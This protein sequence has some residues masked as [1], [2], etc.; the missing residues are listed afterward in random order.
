[1]M[2]REE[3]SRVVHHTKFA[4]LDLIPNGTRAFD[5]PELLGR[6]TTAQLLAELRE[7]YDVIICDSPPLSAG[8]D[9]FVL[10]AAT[11]NLMLVLRAG[12]SLR[13]VTKSKLDV[14]DRMPV[15]LLGAVLNDVRDPS[16]NNIYSYY[17]P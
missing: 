13:D 3:L 2:G 16:V 6:A 5:A 7:K 1:L 8:I 10:G 4:G 12:V 15:R 9:A 17:L 14:L 11:E